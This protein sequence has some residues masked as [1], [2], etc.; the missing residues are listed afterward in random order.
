[1]NELS[2]SIPG[3]QVIGSRN[4]FTGCQDGYRV[5]SLHSSIVPRV[6]QYVLDQKLR[7]EQ[8]ALWDDLEKNH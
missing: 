8:D 1:M 2:G 6:K 7:H 5:I 3:W 4:E